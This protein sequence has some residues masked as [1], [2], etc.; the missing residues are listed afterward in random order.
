MGQV[1][2][3]GPGDSADPSLGAAATLLVR[4]AMFR[5]LLSRAPFPSGV[6]FRKRCRR[7]AH[8]DRSSGKIIFTQ[9]GAGPGGLEPS[10]DLRQVSF[11]TKVGRNAG[12]SQALGSREAGR[13]V[14][15]TSGSVGSSGT[16]YPRGERPQ[17]RARRCTARMASTRPRKLS[18]DLPSLPR[19]QKLSP[20]RPRT[21]DAFGVT[22]VH[23]L[24]SHAGKL[25]PTGDSSGLGSNRSPSYMP[26]CPTPSWKTPQTL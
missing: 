9:S 26:L 18:P 8:R 17:P 5:N 15:G 23:P 25:S 19:L 22:G 2:R 3:E 20:F 21:R 7:K 24:A 14:M 13:R 10:G 16:G 12:S 11:Y 4:C 6:P 1:H